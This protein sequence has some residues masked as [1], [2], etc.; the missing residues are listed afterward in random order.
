MLRHSPTRADGDTRRAAHWQP[1]TSYTAGQP[2][3]T[4]RRR[5]KVTHTLASAVVSGYVGLSV[6]RIMQKI[7]LS[8]KSRFNGSV[9]G[10]AEK[11]MVGFSEVFGRDSTVEICPRPVSPGFAAVRHCLRFVFLCCF[12]SHILFSF[13]H[14]IISRSLPYSNDGLCLCLST[15]LTCQA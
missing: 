4:Q 6:G 11:A 12:V 2:S 1:A 15:A 7:T 10:I 8:K 9:I 14:R 3:P 13:L 5:A